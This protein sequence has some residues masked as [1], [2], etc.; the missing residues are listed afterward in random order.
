MKK[1]NSISLKKQLLIAFS[2]VGTALIVLNLI[3]VGNLKRYNN[4]YYNVV[5]RISLANEINPIIREDLGLEAYYLTIERTTDTQ[6]F[7]DMLTK[8]DNSIKALI[9]DAPSQKTREHL[10]I[11]QRTFNTLNKY[12]EQLIEQVD[13]HKDTYSRNKTLEEIRGV[14]EIMQ[15][16]LSEYISLE[17]DQMNQISNSLDLS[18]DNFI[19]ANRITLAI[20]IV[21]SAITIIS[22]INSIT[23]PIDSLIDQMALVS[24]GDFHSQTDNYKNNELGT[25]TEHFNSLVKDLDF[26]VEQERDQAIQIEQAKLQILQEQINPHFLYNTLETIIWMTESGEKQKTVQLV[27]SLSNF[28]RMVLNQGKSN[29]T[30]KEEFETVENYL[31]IQKIRYED[32]LTFNLFLPER[33]ES[34][35]IPKLSLQP[36]V[37]NALY[38]GL[39]N[40][41]GLNMI[42][43]SVNDNYDF[44]EIVVEDTGIG[45]DNLT[46]KTVREKLSAKEFS[47]QGS[48]V[49][50]QNT[51]QRLKLLFGDEYGIS[52]DSELGMG[53][54]AYVKIPKKTQ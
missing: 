52:I 39:K 16:I 26:L 49:G 53:T 25:L 54:T 36:L 15:I 2:F 4:S 50:L 46:L 9:E 48:G 5:S 32:I 23:K 42:S 45:M 14:A 8:T 11:V 1:L 20:I 38:H 18:V 35:I 28:F 17:I 12:C 43:V 51:Q 34:Y 44:L 24:K 6:N 47:T 13:T 27:K 33:L 37:E 31:N 10:L 7:S 19:V 3:L 41:R 22:V 40:K 29:V 30:L 21:F